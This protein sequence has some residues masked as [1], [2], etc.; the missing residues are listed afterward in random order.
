MKSHS[1]ALK[2]AKKIGKA[3]IQT[4][5][6]I[7]KKLKRVKVKLTKHDW[8]KLYQQAEKFPLSMRM[9]AE[10]HRSGISGNYFETYYHI[11]E[12]N[13]SKNVMEFLYKMDKGTTIEPDTIPSVLPVFVERE[14]PVATVLAADAFKDELKELLRRSAKLAPIHSKLIDECLPERKA[15]KKIVLAPEEDDDVK[16]IKVIKVEYPRGHNGKCPHCAYPLNGLTMRV[17]TD[18]GVFNDMHNSCYWLN[19]AKPIDIPHGM[20]V[21]NHN[22]GKSYVWD[23]NPSKPRWVPKNEDSKVEAESTGQVS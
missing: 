12:S 13:L 14:K 19:A 15:A 16:P 1:K 23:S 18:D 5:R 10:L 21:F 8:F 2:K 22:E 7:P 20:T 9:A 4:A 17:K 11:E 3:T 6:S